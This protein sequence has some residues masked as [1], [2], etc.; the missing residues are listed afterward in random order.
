MDNE[1]NRSTRRDLLRWGAGGG[2][3]ITGAALLGGLHTGS[4]S[5]QAADPIVGSWIVAVTGGSDPNERHIASLNADG[6]SS[7]TNTPYSPPD[8]M[9]GADAMASYSTNGLGVWTATGAGQ[10]RIVFVSIDTD[11]SGNFMDTSPVTVAVT[12]SSDGA[13]F[14]G[15]YR[16]AV[17]DADG[18]ALFA[19]DQDL[20]TVQGTRIIA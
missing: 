9:Q 15:T 18:N 17:R 3:A 19:P 13:S 14:T 6:V 2:A 12:L 10:Y 7:V 1:A 8:P 4:V 5:A 11:T 16:V 20:G